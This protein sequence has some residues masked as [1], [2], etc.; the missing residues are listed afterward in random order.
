VEGPSKDRPN[1]KFACRVHE[2][3]SKILLAALFIILIA[4]FSTL[5]SEEVSLRYFFGWG[6]PPFPLFLL[7]L[8]S[9]VAGMV[10][11]FLVDWRERWKL[12]AKV[13]ELGNRVSA[14]Q[15][16][17]ET[18]TAQQNPVE[19]SPTPPEIAKTTPA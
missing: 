14:L 17:I 11:W 19:S 15:E 3:L 1:F 2:K 4:T 6:T 8:A 7:L 18:L 13:R 16:E 5:N 10:L 12:R 9:L